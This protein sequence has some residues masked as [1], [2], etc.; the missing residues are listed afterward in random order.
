MPTV[1]DLK[2]HSLMHLAELSSFRDKPDISA[3]LLEDNHQAAL[4][5]LQEIIASE[6]DLVDLPEPGDQFIG[7]GRFGDK[8]ISVAQLPALNALPSLNDHNYNSTSAAIILDDNTGLFAADSTSVVGVAVNTDG[9]SQLHSFADDH[10]YFLIL[11]GNADNLIFSDL[12]G[13]IDL[14]VNDDIDAADITATIPTISGNENQNAHLIDTKLETFAASSQAWLMPGGDSDH[15]EIIDADTLAIWQE[16]MSADMLGDGALQFVR[17]E[18]LTDKDDELHQRLS[19]IS[20]VKVDSQELSLG[21]D[22]K[23]HFQRV[24]EVEPLKRNHC[25]ICDRT[26]KKPIDYRRHMRTHTGERPFKCDKCSRSF[27]LRCILLTHLKRHS[28]VKEKHVCHVCQKVFSAKVSLNVHLR[29]HTGSKPFK[30][31]YCDLRFRTSGHRIAHQQCHLRQAAKQKVQPT[32]VKT[33]KAK[34]KLKTIEDVVNVAT[35]ES[36]KG[37]APSTPAPKVVEKTKD[38]KPKKPIVSIHFIQCTCTYNEKSVFFFY[39]SQNP[40][41]S[42]KCCLAARVVRKRST[43]VASY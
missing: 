13:D 31:D 34:S 7:V 1:E 41:R 12:T 30:C 20:V 32:D 10:Q 21:K 4:A 42:Q 29:L 16:P 15:V 39:N 24:N 40:L 8:P 2:E 17:L 22:V 3:E 27:S 9:D 14:A 11:D 38:V 5:D 43:N 36:T 18:S 28:D 26:F 23:G 6:S 37:A 25:Q 35:W 33:R 19:N